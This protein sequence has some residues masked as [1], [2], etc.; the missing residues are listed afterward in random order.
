MDERRSR[1]RDLEAKK[2]NDLN[3]RNRLLEE[4]GGALF[5]RIGE[6]KPFTEGGMETACTVLDEYRGLQKEIDE[7]LN[8]IKS[9]EK[10]VAHLKEL[11]E[12]IFAR[13]EEKSRLEEELAEAYVMAGKQLFAD[14]GSN[15]DS[16][17]SRRQ[18]EELI[19]KIE[20]Q[21]MKLDEL[22][23]REGGVIAWIGKNAQMTVSK[24]LLSR[25]RA[26]LKKI[27]RAEGEKFISTR[28][29][30]GGSS[31]ESAGE[32]L[33]LKGRISEVGDELSDL[34][35]ERRKIGDSFGA[36]GSP[37]RRI[38][39]LEKHIVQVKGKFPAVY[40]RMGSLAAEKDRRE[41]FASFLTAEDEPV[42]DNAGLFKS[43]IESCELEIEK[44]KTS[45]RIDDEKTEI[46]KI[47]K[48]INGQKQKIAAAEKEITD[49]EKQITEAEQHIKELQT[50]L[51]DG[52]KA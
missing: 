41:V 43:R 29:A 1:I 20:E 5:R 13:E 31:S 45:I 7:S 27:Y 2:Q 33:G 50:F 47:G 37:S 18:A 32:I 34:K 39:G 11:E 6:E 15:D 44:I 25:E 51:D 12:V 16:S 24:A 36:E 4:L 52:K 3:A 35:G 38:Q 23:K 48:A 42:L 22:E 10:E 28:D 46:E 9:L 19:A 17:G 21:E 8:L 14:P 49:F 30:L 26:A 40:L